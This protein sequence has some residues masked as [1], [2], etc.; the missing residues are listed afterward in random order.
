MRAPLLSINSRFPTS[1][2]A[3]D[4]LVHEAMRRAKDNQGIAAMLLGITRQSL[5]RRLKNRDSS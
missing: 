3:D 4:F 2:E 5:N 1:K